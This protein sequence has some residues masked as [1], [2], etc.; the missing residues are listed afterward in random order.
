MSGRVAAIDAVQEGKRLTVYIGAAFGGVWKS[1]N[2][3]DRNWLRTVENEFNFAVEHSLRSPAQ[4]LS[5]G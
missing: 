2:G 3:G 4:S 1:L 5:A